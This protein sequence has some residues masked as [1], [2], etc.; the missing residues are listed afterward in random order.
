MKSSL[1]PRFAAALILSWGLVIGRQDL[2]AQSASGGIIGTIRDASGAAVPG[3]TV[4]VTNLRESMTKTALSGPAGEYIVKDL[5]PATYAVVA[6]QP[7]MQFS[8]VVTLNLAAGEQFRADFNSGATDGNSTSGIEQKLEAME[9]RI[10]Q[11]FE[12]LEA[13]IKIMRNSQGQSAV[14]LVGQP[15]GPLLASNSAMSG[16]PQTT[17][18]GAAAAQ[19]NPSRPPEPAAGFPPKAL[20]APSA[21]PA[22]DNFTPFAYGDFTWLNGT[23]RNKDTVLDTK[24]FTPEVRF[25][26]NYIQD[27]NRP[28]DHTIVGSTES[29]RSGEV[30]IEQASV[31]GDFHWD[32][33][34]GRILLMEGL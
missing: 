31:G 12:Q 20:E 14:A 2:Q 30:Q 29:F 7:G 11:R 5:A 26:A 4:R 8:H 1:I 27:F 3:V 17:G 23:S 15:L 33:V 22:V 6:M 32:N 9:N 18:A 19:D 34:R 10:E 21:G 24:F 28:I 16:P 13:E 25:D